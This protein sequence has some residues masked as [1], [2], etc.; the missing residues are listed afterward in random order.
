MNDA[1]TSHDSVHFNAFAIVESENGM[2][3]MRLEPGISAAEAAARQQAVVIDPGPFKSF[4]DAQDA[5]TDL[6]DP[7]VEARGQRGWPTT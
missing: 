4:E 6:M 1:S 5:L 7:D 3:V 2:S